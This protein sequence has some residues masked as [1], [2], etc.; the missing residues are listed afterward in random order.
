MA[1]SDDDP[2]A[3]A[4]EHPLDAV[5]SREGLPWEDRRDFVEVHW[6]AT[7]RGNGTCTDR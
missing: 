4:P 6:R 5:P 3:A 2:H 1:C 7:I